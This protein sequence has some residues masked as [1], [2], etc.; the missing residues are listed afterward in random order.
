MLVKLAYGESGLEVN[1]P[2]LIT[3]V[4]EPEYIPGL[5]D[6][7]AAVQSA[8]RNPIGS[9][10]LRQLISH[11]Q[12]VAI[13]ICDITRPSP[14][15]VVLPIIL[16]EISHIPKDNVS[17]LVATGTHRA[18]SKTELINMVGNEIVNNN[19]IINHDCFDEDNL[20]LTGQTSDGTPIWLNKT[21]VESDV[22]ITCGFVE[23]H[24]FAGFSGG[25]KMVAPGLA[26]FDTIM[27]LHNSERIGST[28][29]VWGITNG[30]PVH[31]TIREISKLSGVDF[32]IDVTINKNRQITSVF[33]GNL[34]EA[35]NAAC[36]TSKRIVMKPVN[37][38]YDIVVTTNSGYPLDQNLYQTVKGLSAAAQIVKP[39][40][41]II[42]ASECR[43]GMPS[44]GEYSKILSESNSMAKLLE[45]INKT[46]QTRHDQWQVQVQAKIQMRAEVLIKSDYLTDTE[47]RAAHFKPISS[48]ESAVADSIN[49]YGKAARICVLPEGPQT[50]PY[51][52]GNI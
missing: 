39:G 12:K 31:D 2:E 52:T 25:P 30:N 21:W 23:P 1:F 11:N 50:V 7:T 32:S 8:L 5:P 44:H 24:F 22:R 40:G 46:K 26:G 43:D 6:E 34:F 10:P 20:V 35:H 38:Q 15:E 18:N 19:Q 28:K 49:K 51:L 4:V 17:I 37:N 13:S 41:T 36:E 47:L 42:C 14:T 27:A 9:K 33:A 45:K 29:A 16:N 3:D 48:I